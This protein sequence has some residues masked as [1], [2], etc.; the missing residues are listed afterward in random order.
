VIVT[1]FVDRQGLENAQAMI[2]AP[3][4]HLP[5]PIR[6]ADS[7]VLLSANGEDRLEEAG[8]RLFQVQF[9][10][11]EYPWPCPWRQLGWSGVICPGSLLFI[12]PCGWLACLSG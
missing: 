7:E 4:N 1:G 3:V 2:M 12:A 10:A 8:V 6:V 11:Q 5:D 9:Q